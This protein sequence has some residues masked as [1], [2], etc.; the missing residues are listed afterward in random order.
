MTSHKLSIQIPNLFLHQ[1]ESA[2]ISG[3]W[4]CN[5]EPAEASE[6]N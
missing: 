4:S 2:V 6:K 3:K 5:P 1:G